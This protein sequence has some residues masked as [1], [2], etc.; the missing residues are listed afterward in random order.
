VADHAEASAK[1]LEAAVAA[2]ASQLGLRADQVDVE[3]LEEP[4]PSTFGVIGSPARVRVT[5]R[6][7][8]GPS[9][10]T[11]TPD[12]AP[13]PALA[14]VGAGGVQEAGRAEASVMTDRSGAPRSGTGRPAGE[15]DGEPLDEE[16]IAAD[17][18]LAAD[19]VEGLLDVLDLDGDITTWVDPTG[20]HVEVEG[21]GLDMLVGVD[22]EVL[23]AL[24]ELT[25]LAVLRQTRHR[26]RIHVDVGGFKA[27]RQQELADMA[28][29]TARR[30]VEN[31][32][33]EQLRPMTPF[34]RKIVHD[35]VREVAGATTESVGEEPQR[36]VVILPAG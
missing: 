23:G 15:R 33:Q 29:S 5:A 24:Q 8:L 11:A 10:P 18:E 6:V 9:T 3:V 13:S 14:S 26:P 28:R 21:T 19:F 31:G 4:V 36:C 32:R 20:G 30:V 1:T 16:A 35:A 17:T 25:R 12:P 7:T 2:A 22:G 27:R 34:E